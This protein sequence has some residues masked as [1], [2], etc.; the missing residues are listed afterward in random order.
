LDKISNVHLIE[1]GHL[2][3]ASGVLVHPDSPGLRFG[4]GLFET[5][6]MQAGVI[7]LWDFHM[8]R[9]SHGMALLGYAFD[10][11]LRNKL[12]NAVMILCEAE[13]CLDRARIRINVF[14]AEGALFDGTRSPFHYLIRASALSSGMLAFEEEGLRVGI[15]S[16]AVRHADE[17][18]ALKTQ[19]YLPS[20]MA[21]RYAAQQGWDDAL[22]LNSSGRIA[23]S[24]IANIFMVKDGAAVTP[25][26]SE[27]CVSGVMRRYLLDVLPPAGI[28][29]F[30]R[31][32]TP[33]ALKTA[34]E[35][36]L[37]NAIRLVRPVRYF[38]EKQYS[39]ELARSIFSLAV[40]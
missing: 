34:D 35:L 38:Q 25:P 8:E 32:L 10:P 3:N 23:E 4:D 30:E 31:P 21:A 15:F 18:S 27:G 29:V 36:F 16:G 37:T 9:L 12:E 11:E 33:E 39:S 5:M 19:N 26:L 6:L 22:L 1:D 28:A 13:Q 20:V 14:R 17:F 40:A 24:A 2:L 7:R